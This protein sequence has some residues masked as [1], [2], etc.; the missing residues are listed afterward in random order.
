M[1]GMEMRNILKIGQIKPLSS[2]SSLRSLKSLSSLLL[3]LSVAALPVRAQVDAEQVTAI[4][5]NV[6][7]M[8]DYMLS[9][10]YFNLAIKAKPYLAE[11]YYLRA[12]AKL[13]LEDYE[14]AEADCTLAIE[15][16]KFITESY[17]VRG[18]ARQYLGRDSLAVIDYD[19][20]L[21]HNPQDRYFLFYKGVALTEL[22]RYAEADSTLSVL[23]RLYPRMDEGLSAH[24]RL[25]VLRGDTVAALADIARAI[26][27]SGSTTI[28]PFLLRADIEVKRRDWPAALADMDQALRLRPEEPEY[29][30]NRAF[31][32]YNNEDYFGAMADYNYTLELQPSNEAAL[33]NRALLRYE[34]GDLNRAA[35]DLEAVLAMDPENFHARYNLGLIDL[36]RNRYREALSAFEAISKRYPRFHPALYAQAE[37]WRGLGNMRAAM[38]AAHRGDELVR[39][40]VSDPGKNPLDRPAIEAGA[41]NDGSHDGETEEQVM[42]RFNQLV[43]SSGASE[44]Q[45]AFNDRIKGRVQDR[46]LNVEPEPSVTLTFAPPAASLQAAD[47]YSRE[48]DDFNSS[49]YIGQRLYISAPRPV[50]DYDA[51]FRLASQ[52][53]ETASLST[54]AADWLALGVA[55]SMLKDYEA[56]RKAFSRALELYPEFT[57]ALL[58]RGAAFATDSDERLRPLAM[59]DYDAALKLNPSLAPA[60]LDKGNL[61]YASG[62]CT[63]AVDAYSRAIEADAS[64]GS[65]WYNRGLAYLRLGN[66]VQAFAD[67]RRAGELGVLPSYNLLKRMK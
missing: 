54:R 13:S 10:Q 24:A 47:A 53:E 25:N 30:L 7:S 29:Y 40:Y 1:I 67:L 6:L 60:W 20:G 63:S 8:E 14:G 42:D 4:G 61:L 38:Q 59:E 5:R 46:N 50:E 56:A 36:E 11:P 9:I 34:V 65:A 16:N 37:A 49:G 19:T 62:D 21:A 32:R 31:I 57:L 44:T 55:R 52:L 18:F 12:L 39:A 48:V 2:L 22:N 33:F 23:L 3:L 26:E 15:R 51:L 58:G 17:R 45:L 64:L 43:T 27:L 41:A 28:Q 35:A 66:R